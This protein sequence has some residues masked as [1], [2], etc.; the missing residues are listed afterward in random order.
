[1]TWFVKRRNAY[2]CLKQ[3]AFNQHHIECAVVKIGQA[4]SS[5]DSN[6][7]GFFASKSGL[8]LEEAVDDLP[9]NSPVNA[10]RSFFPRATDRVTFFFVLHQGHVA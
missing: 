4:H 5:P 9:F 2:S 10:N 1:M 6:L 8:S 3:F 7:C